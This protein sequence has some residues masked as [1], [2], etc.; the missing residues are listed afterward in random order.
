MESSRLSSE[1]LGLKDYGSG[2]DPKACINLRNNSHSYVYSNVWEAYAVIGICIF[3]YTF[4]SMCFFRNR[5]K[6]SYMT[7]SPLTVSLSLV[8]LGAD[9]VTNTLIFSGQELGDLFHWQC[10]LGITATVLGQ[11][12]FMLATGMRI[13]RISKVYNEYL[14]YLEI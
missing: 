2:K 7:R 13:Y 1:L 10:N 11:F 12:G 9:T 3:L 4:F 6:M 5:N 8:M 14:A